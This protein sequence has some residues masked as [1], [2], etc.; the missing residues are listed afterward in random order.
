[1]KPDA[2]ILGFS[3]FCKATEIEKQAGNQASLTKKGHSRAPF[4]IPVQTGIQDFVTQAIHGLRPAG[5]T[6]ARPI[7]LSCRIVPLLLW[8][9]ASLALRS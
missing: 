7:R 2:V 3:G 1:V 4:V 6:K 9:F 8:P 5:A